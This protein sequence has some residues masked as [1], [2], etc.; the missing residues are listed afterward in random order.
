MWFEQ[1]RS[2]FAPSTLFDIRLHTLHTQAPLRRVEMVVQTQD[3]Q[4]GHAGAVGLHIGSVNVQQYFPRSVEMVELELDHLR[5]VCQLEPSF[6]QDCP[7]IHDQRLSS[8]LESKRNSGKL[9]LQAAPVA[10][11]PSGEYSFRLQIMTKDE[12]EFSLSGPPA[13]AYFSPT[14]SPA[15]LLERR[16][17]ASKVKSDR[18]KIA[19][20]KGNERPSP[21]KNN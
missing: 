19:R 21:A 15:V 3:R 17:H 2:I 6:W 5:I 4:M 16:R 10:M 20:L 13:T 8:W 9:G 18:R 7:E 14:V 1:I 11:I 12:V